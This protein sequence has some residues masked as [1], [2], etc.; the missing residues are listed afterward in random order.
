MEKHEYPRLGETVARD[1]LPNGMTVFAVARPR[2]ARSYAC[3]AV[4]Y[5]GMD[6]RFSVGG[7]RT[8][9][10]AG[11]A[12]Y[13]EHK[14]FDMPYGSVSERFAR[15]GASDNAFTSNAV[16]VYDVVCTEKFYEC[17]RLL[18]E[19]VSTPYFT[20]ESVEKERGIISQEIRMV[21]D[22][23]GW[24]VYANLMGCLYARSPVRFDVAGTL[25]SI[26]SITAGTLYDCHRAFYT[27]GNMALVCVG[28]VEPER[29]RDVALETLPPSGGE[30]PE[31]DYGGEE[32]LLP[33]RREA[34]E[35]M[36]VSMPMFLAGFKCPPVERGE[37]YL[38]AGM[39]GDLACDAL[40]GDSSP[41][42]AR[43][44]ESGDINGS[45][46]GNVDL[47]PGACYLNVGGDARDPEKVSREI[48]R[49][50]RRLGAGGIDAGFFTQL[51]RAAYGRMVR[52]LNS[53]ENIAVSL[54]EGRFRDFDYFR[55]PE[56]FGSV[57]KEDVEAFLRENI[58]EERAALSVIEPAQVR[59]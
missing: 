36:E 19:F 47:L 11:V 37:A 57:T 33:C 32:G 2:Y 51:R 41:L 10:P 16:T 53:F 14:V 4:R 18:L 12:H 45:L 22:D 30:V 44:Y 43:L 28:D 39:V 17:L 20:P 27:P 31:R 52:S 54:S 29:V 48:V 59:R 25:E 9:T 26:R 1:V 40:F 49:E 13:L 21:T 3:L 56:V 50:A 7:K 5:G 46:G 15:M 23:P 58:T 8:D 55:F 42:F 24:R 6:T 34:R 35:S 38:R